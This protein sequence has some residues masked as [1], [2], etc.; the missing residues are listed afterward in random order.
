[1]GHAN[2]RTTRGYQHPVREAAP[3]GFGDGW[4]AVFGAHRL[5]A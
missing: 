5:A 1:M 4:P 3:E 2:E